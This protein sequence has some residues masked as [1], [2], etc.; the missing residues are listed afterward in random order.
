MLIKDKGARIPD[1]L[2]KSVTP[3]LAV[4]QGQEID[5]STPWGMRGWF[6]CKW[7]DD[8][9]RIRVSGHQAGS[10]PTADTI[11]FATIAGSCP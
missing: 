10:P 3:M 2:N 8:E 11:A 5:L 4:S 9:L 1:A 7:R 6:W